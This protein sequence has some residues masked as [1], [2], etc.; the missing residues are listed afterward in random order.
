VSRLAVALEQRGKDVWVDVEGVRDAEVFPEALR[1]AI[2]SSDAF[3]FVISPDAVKSSFCVEEV[4]H[5]AS[6]NKRIVPIAL[7][8]V[9]DDD[10]PDE[11]RFRNWIPAG[12]DGQL[13][14]AV[15]RLVKALDTDL[16]WEREHSRLTV[17]A[18]E[19]ERSGRDRSSLLRG[20]E[21]RSAE[22]WLAVGA[23]KDPGP[24]AIEQEYLLAARAARQRR[25]RWLAGA[26]LSVAAVAIGL[27]IFALISRNQ[28]VRAARVAVARQLGAEAVSE[29]RID[30]A[31]LLAREAVNLNRDDQTG[32]TLL[33]TLLRSPAAIGTFALPIDVRPQSISLRPDGRVLAVTDNTHSIRFYDPRTHQPI[34]TPRTDS[35]ETDA[36]TYSH[37]SSLVAYAAAKGNSPFVAVRDAHTLRLV[38]RLSFDHRWLTTQTGDLV[39]A[40][41]AFLFSPGN[42]VL[43]Y[44]YFVVE[45][46][47]A[48]G[49]A[50]L[51]RW[52]L[53]SGR[54]LSTTPIGP[55][56]V[57]AARLVNGRL[58]I[59]N[60]SASV[61]YD[62]RTL[63]RLH[64]RS[65]TPAPGRVATGD[66]SPDGRSAVIGHP[67]GSV[68][69]VNL[70]TGRTRQGVGGHGAGVDP[71]IFSPDGRE[72]VTA[73]EDQ[74]VIVWDPSTAQPIET[75]TG[76]AG[77]VHGVAF[78]ANGNTLY[79]SSL[80]GVV[81]GWDLGGKRR[82][83]QPLTVGPGLPHPGIGNP[84]APLTP[85]LAFSPDGSHFAVRIGR[86]TIGL[87]SARTLH[88]QTSF[89]AHSFITAL[90]WSPRNSEVAVGA[91]SGAVSLWSVAGPPH[92][93]RSLGGLPSHTTQLHAVQGLSFSSDGSLVAAVDLEENRTP[94]GGTMGRLAIWHTSSGALLHPPR[95]LHQAGDSIAFAPQG[96]ELAVGLDRGHV[97][98]VDPRT[99]R[100]L[101]SL[102]TLGTASTSLVTSLAFAPNGT[103][104]TGSWGGIVQ[105]WNPTSG[106]ELGHAVLVAG[107]PVSTVAFDPSGRRFATTGGSDG[108]AK[109]W[110]TSTLQQEGAN[111]QSDPGQW[112]NAVFSP[113][114]TTLLVLYGDGK[115]FAWPATTRAWEQH[116]C[117]V[118]GR[119][120]TREEWSRFVSGYSYAKVC[121]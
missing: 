107:A 50:Y 33:A 74:K 104:A 109:I 40:P 2:E 5:A 87:F 101:R 98:I 72:A 62:A 22:E 57:L 63:R 78:S 37:N 88:E 14:G 69:F 81:L 46:N 105:L 17:R 4:E 70:E 108:S 55:G 114:G 3:V 111:L 90:G 89:D 58:V 8:P 119:N 43:Y 35:I 29:P 96:N 92:I 18:L 41:G 102:T 120:L 113:D 80:D 100:L 83:G 15:E 54:L 52:S 30:R 67:T 61:V 82:F 103:L 53:R 116:A 48:V 38:R 49:A 94:S 86:T 19:W 59:L 32:G 77:P 91:Y 42:R 118:A 13:D 66:I 95:Q 73:G 12:G 106:R 28:A 20:S 79:T 85:P 65:I 34:G 115:G 45:P 9:A 110:F 25:Q 16:D 39:N 76:H 60:G 75:L 1:R 84:A 21:L 6:L 56:P 64:S 117:A 31:M 23:D 36:P 99:G 68:S 93:E 7:R 26:S 27:L 44:P 47:G 24:S 51:D 112:G 121:R 10:L 97:L 11:V 71:A